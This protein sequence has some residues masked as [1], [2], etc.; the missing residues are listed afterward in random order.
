[1]ISEGKVLN[2]PIRATAAGCEIEAVPR[3]AEL[4]IEQPGL[5]NEKAVATPG[6]SGK[7]KGDLPNNTPLCG[8][9]IACFRGVAVGRLKRFGRYFKAYPRDVWRYD[10]QGPMTHLEMYTDADWAGCRRARKSTWGGVAMLGNHC[11]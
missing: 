9:D 8:S 3:H 6:P 1:M 5:K 10:F 2:R 11:I 7:D 4:V